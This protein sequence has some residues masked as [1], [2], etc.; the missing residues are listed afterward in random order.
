MLNNDQ[1]AAWRTFQKQIRSSNQLLDHRNTLL[2]AYAAAIALD[3]DPCMQLLI[4]ESKRSGIRREELDEVMVHV[5]AVAAQQKQLLAER[6]Q[7]RYDQSH[8]PY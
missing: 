6:A 2:V 5:M 7:Q 1:S 3:C 8:D 4:D